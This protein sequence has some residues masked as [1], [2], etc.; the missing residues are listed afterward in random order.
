MKQAHARSRRTRGLG[1]RAR[2]HG[3]VG[4]LR[5]D[6]RGRGDRARSSARSSSAATSSTPPTCTGRTPTRS[7]S[8]ARS[9]GAATRSSSRPSSASSRSE[10]TT[11]CAARR[12]Q[13]RVRAHACEGSLQRLG[14]D[15]IDLYYQHRVDPNTPIEETVGAMAELVQRGQGPPHRS[16]RGSAPRRSA[17][18]TPCTRSPPCRPSTRCGRATSRRRSCRRCSE[19]G[20]ALGRLLAARRGFLSGAS[21]RPRSSTRATSAAT[22]RAS[23]ARTCRQN[24]KLAERVKELAAEMGDHARAARAR[25][26]AAP[27]R[28][29]RADPRHQARSS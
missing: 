4:L 8:A 11:R 9:Q 28:A 20:I 15:H 23:R 1:D 3:H 13:P 6:R 7:S 25:V 12:R 21:P 22:A 26:G 14:T 18:R 29:H 19:L 10:P 27:R 16:L 5:T 2:L 17:A 24:L